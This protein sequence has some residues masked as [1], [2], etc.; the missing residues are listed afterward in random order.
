MHLNFKNSFTIGAMALWT[1]SLVSI[2]SNLKTIK[3]PP[4]LQIW[5][6]TSLSF[7]PLCMQ[8]LINL[9]VSTRIHKTKT[10]VL[11]TFSLF[12]VTAVTRGRCFP[13]ISAS[14]PSGNTLLPSLGFGEWQTLERGK[15]EKFQGWKIPRPPMYFLNFSLPLWGGR[16]HDKLRRKA[17]YWG[18]IKFRVAGCKHGLPLYSLPGRRHLQSKNWFCSVWAQLCFS[19][20]WFLGT[21]KMN[22]SV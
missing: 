22:C 14:L 10:C 4:T 9:S 19:W 6:M 20:N 13:G 5:I 11:S 16:H 8:N 2:V 7:T 17:F 12:P 1:R 18:K 21:L 3:K 15:A